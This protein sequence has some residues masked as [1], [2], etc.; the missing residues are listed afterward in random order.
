MALVLEPRE[1]R[2]DCAIANRGLLAVELEQFQG[3][4]ALEEVLRAPIPLQRPGDRLLIGLAAAVAQRGECL[5]VALTRTPRPSG[6]R[7]SG[8][9]T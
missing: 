1:L 6:S 5:G 3:L 7:L 4:P 2:L 9:A 8:T